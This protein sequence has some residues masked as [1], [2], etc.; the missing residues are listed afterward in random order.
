MRA[1]ELLQSFRDPATRARRIFDRMLAF[2]AVDLLAFVALALAG[3][4]VGVLVA[5]LAF[6]LRARARTRDEPGGYAG[7]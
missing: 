5:G 4:T 7:L 3:L 6:W 2:A 1:H